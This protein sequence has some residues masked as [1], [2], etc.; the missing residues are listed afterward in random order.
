MKLDSTVP[1]PASRLRNFGVNLWAEF[2]S[3]GQFIKP[4]GL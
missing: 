4:L 3:L 1:P 2:S